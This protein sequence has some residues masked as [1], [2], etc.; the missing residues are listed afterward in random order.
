MFTGILFGFLAAILNSVGYLFSA[1]YLLSY[2]S[3]VR[4]LVQAQVF[5]MLI[6]LPF[7]IWLFPFKSITDFKWLSLLTLLWVSVFII[8]QGCF[9]AA[10][11]YFESSRLAS[12]LGLK[13][14]VLS[15]F[16][17][18]SGRGML[19]ALQIC[20]VILAAI[21][22]MAF[23]WSGSGRSDYRGWLL[24]CVTL[25]CYSTAD[26]NETA[27]ILRVRES[28]NSLVMSTFSVAALLY[29]VLGLVSIPFLFWFR[30]T[31]D[32]ACK[33]FPYSVLWLGSQIALFVCFALVLPVFGNV[34]LATRGVFSVIIGACLPLFGLASLDSQISTRKWIQRGVASVLMALAIALYSFGTANA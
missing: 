15:I 14:I 12:L 31:F 26:L 6:A 19:N 9:F 10:Q 22:G 33:A 29:T 23:N 18:A 11:K 20:A 1:R 28:G 17:V 24:L 13:I 3:P 30:P 5:M 8:G 21:A 32:Q 2:K 4:L 27:L 7:M 34:I 16:F 25:V